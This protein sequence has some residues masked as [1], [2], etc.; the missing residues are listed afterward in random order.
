M[1]ESIAYVCTF[2]GIVK[3]I[4]FSVGES[5]EKR[6]SGLEDCVELQLVELSWLARFQ[7]KSANS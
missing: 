1:E 6:R 5:P 3:R 4:H 7:R 2:N